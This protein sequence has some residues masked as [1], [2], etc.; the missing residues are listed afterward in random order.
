MSGGE[1]TIQRGMTGLWL[2]VVADWE[3]I[4]DG[5]GRQTGRVQIHEYVSS[6][7]TTE[8]AAWVAAHSAAGRAPVAS[9]TSNVMPLRVAEQTTILDRVEAAP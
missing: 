7:H 1:I 5:R 8:A 3:D 9:L 4:L 2:V 6:R